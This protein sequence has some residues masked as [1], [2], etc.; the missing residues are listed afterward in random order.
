[1]DASFCNQATDKAML[2]RSNKAKDVSA[3]L[4]VTLLLYELIDEALY[5]LAITG[6]DCI[7]CPTYVHFLVHFT[8]YYPGLSN[9]H[10]KNIGHLTN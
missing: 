6:R 8:L 1:M 10:K 5:L 2:F 7:A 9:N 4:I 3:G